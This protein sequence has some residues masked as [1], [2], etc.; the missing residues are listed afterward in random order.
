MRYG[1]SKLL[2]S[3]TALASPV[4]IVAFDW[5]Y[6]DDASEVQLAQ[7]NRGL[8]TLPRSGVLCEAEACKS[9]TKSK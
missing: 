1:L 4:A 2:P 8:F 9:I 7:Q 5:F 6:F 3:I